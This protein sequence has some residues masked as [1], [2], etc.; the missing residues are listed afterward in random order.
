MEVMDKAATAL[1]GAAADH[2]QIHHMGADGAPD[3]VLFITAGK[4]CVAAHFPGSRLIKSRRS[5]TTKTL[6]LMSV[7]VCGSYEP[8]E[9]CPFAP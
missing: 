9:V 5:A 7:L 1:E 4:V 3:M 2:N 6:T 8:G